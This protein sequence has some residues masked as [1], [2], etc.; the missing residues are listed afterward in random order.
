MN[1][2]AIYRS[3]VAFCKRLGIKPLEFEDW[4]VTSAKDLK[5]FSAQFIW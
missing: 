4:V 3:Y 1:L 5:Q 2:E